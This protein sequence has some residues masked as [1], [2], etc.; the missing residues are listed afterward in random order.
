[1]SDPMRVLLMAEGDAEPRDSWS[2]ISKNVLMGLRSRGHGVI[3]G[4][5]ELSGIIDGHGRSDVLAGS[6][7]VEREVRVGSASV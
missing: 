3:A 5:V 7:P 6:A 2:G 4:E 1:M